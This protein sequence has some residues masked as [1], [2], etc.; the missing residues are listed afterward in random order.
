M[1]TIGIE[2]QLVKEWTRDLPP[3]GPRDTARVPWELARAPGVAICWGVL[4]GGVRRK[5]E[6][7]KAWYRLRWR[8]DLLGCRQG[9]SQDSVPTGACL[10]VAS[11]DSLSP[12]ALAGRNLCSRLARD[13]PGTRHREKEVLALCL[14]EAWLGDPAVSM[15][16]GARRG[17]GHFSG[18]CG[19]PGTERACLTP[20]GG[21]RRLPFSALEKYCHRSFFNCLENNKSLGF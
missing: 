6:R 18:T 19:I 4:G 8:A 2:A 12:R 3:A 21:P 13:P 17:G 11:K 5:K 9:G 1:L 10:Y 20:H 16:A 15:A 14:L 7:E